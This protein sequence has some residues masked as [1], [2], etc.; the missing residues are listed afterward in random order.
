M[1][2]ES[3]VGAMLLEDVCAA[4]RM[5]RAGLRLLMITC[6][7]VERWCRCWRVSECDGT[8]YNSRGLA[9]IRDAD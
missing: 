8:C 2:A 4:S 7:G 9:R 6:S 3:D 5:E 1:D